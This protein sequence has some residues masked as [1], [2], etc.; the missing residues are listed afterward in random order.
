MT[1][2]WAP[3]SAAIILFTACM[4]HMVQTCTADLLFVACSVCL[5]R[6]LCTLHCEVLPAAQRV[7]YTTRVHMCCTAQ[8]ISRLGAPNVSHTAQPMSGV[9]HK[10]HTGG[11]KRNPAN[12][13]YNRYMM[14]THVVC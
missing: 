2:S 5:Q 11:S 10:D 4:H 13:V 3:P 1:P 12:A 14:G 7:Q 9:H 8:C 6:A